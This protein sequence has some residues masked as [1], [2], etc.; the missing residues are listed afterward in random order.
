M[1]NKYE[2]SIKRIQ[3]ED[4]VQYLA[5]IPSMHIVVSSRTALG[6]MEALMDHLIQ[7]QYLAK[8]F[9]TTVF[10]YLEKAEDQEATDFWFE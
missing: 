1:T 2:L 10:N 4:G 7:R 6:A 8:K 3:I 5:Q 9:D